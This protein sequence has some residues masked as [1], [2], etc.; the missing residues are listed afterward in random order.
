MPQL[1]QRWHLP[2]LLL[3]TVLVFST[4]LL[5]PAFVYDDALLLVDNPAMTSLAGVLSGDL[6]AGVPDAGS[7]DRKS[8][9]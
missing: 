3:A 5:N 2:L 1:H 8:V 6:W 9:V 7:Q 4:G